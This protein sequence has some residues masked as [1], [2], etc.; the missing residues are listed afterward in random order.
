MDGDQWTDEQT[1]IMDEQMDRRMKECIY[2][3]MN[4]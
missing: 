2:E 4:G 1:K 3:Q